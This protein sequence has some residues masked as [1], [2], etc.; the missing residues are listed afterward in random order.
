MRCGLVYSLCSQARRA[1]RGTKL[2]ASLLVL[3]GLLC[4]IGAMMEL[5]P[6]PA[7]AALMK[8]SFDEQHRQA[9]C[10]L[11]QSVYQLQAIGQSCP[12]VG[13]DWVSWVEIFQQFLVD[14]VG[15]GP[16]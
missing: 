3:I 2:T 6:G 13:L 16:L 12:W 1:L 5:H 8:L 7:I 14:W 11:G 4:V 9:I 10:A 15:L